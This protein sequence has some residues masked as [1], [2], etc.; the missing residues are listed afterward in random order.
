MRRISILAGSIVVVV[1][2]ACSS[3]QPTA[4]EEKAI[5]AEI[6]REV[7]SA[8]DLKSG[9]VEKGF[10]RLYADTG[11]IV[12]ASGGTVIASRDTLFAG[13]H[14]FWQYVGSNMRNPT[15]MWDRIFVDVLSRD[16]AVM[17]AT[18]HV[19]HLTPRN[20]PHVIGGAWTAVF[21]K[22]DGRWVIIQEHLS[23]LPPAMAD[24]LHAHMNM[25]M[26]DTA[27]PPR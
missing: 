26:P 14:A 21:R 1:A 24:S 15:W 10:E 17:T 25:A 7:R 13:I 6:E 3:S 2:A 8:Y 4:A 5:A 20:M 19:P 22:E 9:N 23:D 16:A 11:R 18:Y 12:S 27:K